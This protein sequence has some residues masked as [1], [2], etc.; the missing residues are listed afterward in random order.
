[1]ERKQKK[2]QVQGINPLSRTVKTSNISKQEILVS[3]GV[4]EVLLPHSGNQDQ[5]DLHLPMENIV[6]ITQDDHITNPKQ[7]DQ[8]IEIME[9]LLHSENQDQNEDQL[10][11]S[12]NQDQND[13]HDLSGNLVLAL[14]DQ[15]EEEHEVQKNNKHIS[16]CFILL[17]HYH[18]LQ[19]YA[20]RTGI[21]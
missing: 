17:Y 3:K 1:M 9:K 5:N 4:D 15:N 18:A 11:D 21:T 20:H 12:G 16:Q 19:T 14:H 7:N 6:R 10:E 13:L 2:D 8:A